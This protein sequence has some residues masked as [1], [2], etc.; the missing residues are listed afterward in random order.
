MAEGNVL[1][2]A[3][4]GDDFTGATDALESLS[5]AG[6]RTVLFLDDPTPGRTARFG[7]LDAVG[8]A[9]MTRSMA[10]AEM[11][12]RLAKSFA[13]LKSLNPKHVHYKVCS[14]FDSSLEIGSIGT[15]IET[16]ARVFQNAFTPVLAAAPHLGRYSAFGNLY[17]RM[18]IGSQ[19]AIYRLD[20]H[21]SMRAHP[22]TPAMESDL[23]LHLAQQT[24]LPMGLVDL[25]DLSKPV[26]EIKA[27][28]EAEIGA[29][30]EI[31]FFD[32][33]YEHQMATIGEILD[34]KA[35][36]NPPLFSVGSSGIEKALGD[37]WAKGGL[38]R[39][40]QQWE[41]LS[42]CSPML[43]LS[44]SVSPVT[45]SQIEWAVQRGFEEVPVG[46]GIVSDDASDCLIS[47]YEEKLV[48]SLRSGKSAILHTAK[49]PDDPRIPEIRSSLD[50]K[51]WDERTRR[52][53]TAMIL[54]RALGQ[55]AR[56][57]LTQCPAG[58]LVIAGGDTASWAARE[59]GI[60]AVEMMAPLFPGAPLCRA[61]ASGSPVDGIEINLKG[62]QVGDETYFGALLKGRI[63][64]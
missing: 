39:P 43:V 21:P 31:V 45:A 41:P 33:L 16:G 50:Q 23:R 40:R 14:T 2:L 52:I 20:R 59:L 13:V 11:E 5:R 28:L 56:R 54:G 42:E 61:Y 34:W 36:E 49:G 64:G 47:A 37:F 17:A 32:A 6:L 19:G 44:G 25:V 26:P 48:K 8:V 63:T 18:G 35:G 3:Y 60:E 38:F 9:G 22:I 58:R 1:S 62:G 30:K 15:A 51:G 27:R 4:Y 24:R 46:A 7:D 55:A 29:G 12:R 53:R 10:P 57:A